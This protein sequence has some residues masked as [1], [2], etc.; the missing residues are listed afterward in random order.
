MIGRVLDP[1]DFLDDENWH[2]GYYELAV[3]LG[4]RGDL[5]SGD[6]LLA[7]RDALWATE[8][9]DGPYLDRW[10]QTLRRGPCAA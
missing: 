7:A 10:S 9:L 4:D 3:D 6:R 2:G 1:T 8:D 5:D